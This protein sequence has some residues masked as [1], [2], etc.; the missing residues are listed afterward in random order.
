MTV[1]AAIRARLAQL[2]PETLELVDE[3]EKHRG[4]AGW[5]PG[6][7]THWRLL[8]V[9]SRFANQT[10]VARHRMVYASLG[11]LMQH[12]IHALSIQARVPGE[13]GA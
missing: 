10:T 9:S 1:E 5:Q 12:P 11:E 13:P 8:I 2:E 6:G 3:S 4:H 7:S